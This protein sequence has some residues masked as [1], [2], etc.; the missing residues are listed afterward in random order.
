MET[1][2]LLRDMARYNA[3]SNAKI[4]AVSATLSDAERKRDLGAFFGSVHGTLNHLLL[5][6]RM[7]L[8]RMRQMP[9]AAKTLGDEV[10]GDFAELQ[11]LRVETDHEITTM[12]RDYV[13]AD[14]DMPLTYFSLATG[15]ARRYPLRD[16][17]LHIGNHQTHH[18]GQITAMLQ[19]LGCDYGD[20][21]LLFMPRE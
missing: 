2:H 10:A 8:A 17:W 12:L 21:D 19:Q 3:W 15:T 5:T 7:W 16:A 6:D 11:R 14:L 13:E 1:I 4:Y 20:V 9:V 18:R